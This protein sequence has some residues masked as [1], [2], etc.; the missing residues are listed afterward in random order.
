MPISTGIWR[1]PCGEEGKDFFCSREEVFH[2]IQEEFWHRIW[3]ESYEELCEDYAS[4][5]MG[6]HGRFARFLKSGAWR[7][8]RKSLG[9]VMEVFPTSFWCRLWCQVTLEVF[10]TTGFVFCAWWSWRLKVLWR[11]SLLWLE[12]SAA[13]VGDWEEGSFVWVLSCWARCIPFGLPWWG[14]HISCSLLSY[15][16][17]EEGLL[18]LF[19]LVYKVLGVRVQ[20]RARVWYSSGCASVVCVCLVIYWW[21]QSCGKIAIEADCRASGIPHNVHLAGTCHCTRL[22]CPHTTFRRP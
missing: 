16:V 21:F 3:R 4:E 9:F 2:A 17:L 12:E 13:T 7:G 10:V 15:Q 14:F 5:S 19:F 6:F 1:F 8:G 18:R 11:P 22:P 20:V